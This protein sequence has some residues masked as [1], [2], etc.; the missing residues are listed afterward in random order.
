MSKPLSSQSIS[1]AVQHPPRK[2]SLNTHYV[3]TQCFQ[4]GNT[5]LPETQ[6]FPHTTKRKFHGLVMTW[7]GRDEVRL[8]ELFLL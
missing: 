7:Q 2:P 5:M 6:S 8:Q 1:S 4:N 3:L